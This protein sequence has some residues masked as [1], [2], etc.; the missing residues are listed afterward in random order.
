MRKRLLPVVLVLLLVTVF[1]SV[2]AHAAISMY[3]L[4]ANLNY[5]G[6]EP[7]VTDVHAGEN[8]TENLPED[9]TRD[10]YGFNGWFLE[11]ECINEL[12]IHETV[13]GDLT[14]YACWRR[15]IEYCDINGNTIK[16]EKYLEITP[17]RTE[18]TCGEDAFITFTDGC[19]DLERI[20][21]NGNVTYRLILKDGQKVHASSIGLGNGTS[22]EISGQQQDTGELAILSGEVGIGASK[23][24]ACGDI[25]VNGGILRI[26]THSD[27]CIGTSVSRS[28]MTGN[29]PS[30]CGNITVNGGTIIAETLHAACIGAGTA[31]GSKT[32]AGDIT[33]NGGTLQLTTQSGTCIGTGNAEYGVSECGDITI[34]GGNITMSTHSSAAIGTAS[35]NMTRLTCGDVTVNGGTLTAS[36]Y[37]G[38]TVGKVKSL[39]V[40]GGTLKG[41]T[42]I[43][44]SVYAED[45]VRITGGSVTLKGNGSFSVNLIQCA[46]SSVDESLTVFCGPSELE[47]TKTD[48]IDQFG[49]NY[50]KIFSMREICD[51][52]EYSVTGDSY[53]AK[54]R[55]DGSTAKLK[56]SGNRYDH[57][58]KPHGPQFDPEELRGWFDQIGIY[59][60]IQYYRSD[61]RTLT[62]KEHD[63]ADTE[64]GMPSEKGGYIARAEFEVMGKAL[65]LPVRFEIIQKE[66]V[67]F[68][69]TEITIKVGETNDSVTYSGPIAHNLEV[70]DLSDYDVIDAKTDSKQLKL[71]IT[72]KKVGTSEI[73]LEPISTLGFE[74]IE[75]II[76]VITVHVTDDIHSPTPQTGDSA[77]TTLWI[78]LLAVSSAALGAELVLPKKKKHI[79]R[80]PERKT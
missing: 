72:G 15:P 16:C 7:I 69:T 33:V 70:F 76:P 1:F 20:T 8:V 44:G 73:Y 43:S 28:D 55:T 51:E 57:D 40:N 47:C 42:V 25:T 54:S 46:G 26:S 49:I 24:A 45:Q 63:G 66:T 31:Y 38:Y 12:D 41:E 19:Q 34:N 9:P 68:S 79:N 23:G 13:S 11:S 37:A 21:L 17:E 56:L 39:T 5:E 3:K 10:G 32:A 65:T 77:N 62:N 30:K 71:K 78:V 60:S 48:R 35:E 6:A 67:P 22:I 61:G 4:T 50:V 27:A 52:Y 80:R 18:F 2:P 53:T 64:G 58:G 75:F 29:D 14:V 36:S 59:P 74:G